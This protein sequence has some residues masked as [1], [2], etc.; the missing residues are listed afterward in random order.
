M[1]LP[2]P[3]KPVT[4][5]TGSLARVFMRASAW[6]VGGHDERSGARP[7]QWIRHRITP[8]GCLKACRGRSPGSRPCAWRGTFAFPLAQWRM[9]GPGAFTVAG[10][11]VALTTFPLSSGTRPENLERAKATQRANDGQS[12]QLTLG[13][14]RDVLARFFQVPRVVVRGVKREVGASSRGLVRRCPRNG[15]RT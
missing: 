1:V 4:M 13:R 14:T 8:P 3:R 11:A 7:A 2:A 12:R 10:A 5:V 9:K 6:S 15:K